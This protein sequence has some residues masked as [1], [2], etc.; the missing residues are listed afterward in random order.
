M[1]PTVTFVMLILYGYMAVW[2]IVVGWL[3]AVCGKA[4]WAVCFNRIFIKFVII[5][6]PLF[7]I[8]SLSLDNFL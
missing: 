1:T 2:A 6:F 3:M 8:L 5:M 4:H 7:G